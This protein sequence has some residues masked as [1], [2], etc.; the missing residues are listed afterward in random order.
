MQFQ[1]QHVDP[2][3]LFCSE[4][5]ER[6]QLDTPAQ[7][8]SYQTCRT[9]ELACTGLNVPDDDTATSEFAARVVPTASAAIPLKSR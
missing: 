9:L 5:Y 2:A 4:A 7:Q 8:T 3:G 6:Y 1:S